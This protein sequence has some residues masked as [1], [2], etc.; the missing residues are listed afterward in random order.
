MLD[1][2]ARAYIIDSDGNKIKY[3][4]IYHINIQGYK[5]STF[6]RYTKAQLDSYM[7]SSETGVEDWGKFGGNFVVADGY[8]T[9]AA[10]FNN[11]FGDCDPIYLLG[12][13]NST[14][15]LRLDFVFTGDYLISAS[16]FNSSNTGNTFKAYDKNDVLLSPY[17]LYIPGSQNRLDDL[18]YN[19][20]TPLFRMVPESV[21][22]ETG[23]IIPQSGNIRD[24]YLYTASNIG[25]SISCIAQINEYFY[26]FLNRQPANKPILDDNDPY[27]PGGNTSTGGGDGDFTDTT[28][29]I[30]FP[31]MP[32]FSAVDTGFITI[33][34]PTIAQLK[35]LAD[36]MWAGLFDVNAFRKIFA[37]P[38]DAILGVSVVPCAVPQAST[39]R[40]IVV[41]NIPTGIIMNVA[42]AQYVDIDCGTLNISEYW[43]AY[44]DYSPYT[45][46]E[47]YL[48][49]IGVRP[50]SADD[51]MAKQIHL[52]YRIDILS[53]TCVAFIKC[54]DSVLYTF[55]G[56]CSAT[57]PITGNDWSTA[58]MAAVSVA[59]SAVATV[60]TGGLSAPATAGSAAALGASAA[61]GIASAANQIKPEIQKSGAMSG[62]GGMLG[63]QT[64]FL[65]LTRPRQALPERQNTFTGYPSFVT[66]TLGDLEGYTEVAYI[67]LE[68]IP[69]TTSEINELESI[70]KSGVIL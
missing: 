62:V 6:S 1:Y 66:E 5:G 44:L 29:P 47:I 8:I 3:L 7:T 22:S 45:K 48:P 23:F 55:Q 65:I 46:V 12:T 26:Q 32:T 14:Y 15:R 21:M 67:H 57:I 37:D 43:G 4:G 58:I 13:T 61:T 20:N 33:F 28:T 2:Y 40:E 31:T 51:V 30:D 38:G 54:G 19:H 69:A 64:P 68:N 18:T 11:I 10:Y 42:T 9:N 52:M 56:Q 49:F 50:L 16:T 70:L 25:D 34:N 27:K 35:S 24:F 36:Y 41:G 63:I 17:N 39:P 53:G 60:A 59:C